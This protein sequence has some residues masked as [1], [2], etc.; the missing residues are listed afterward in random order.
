MLWYSIDFFN[1]TS[2]T[3]LILQ[4]EPFQ[5]VSW[6]VGTWGPPPKSIHKKLWFS[7]RQNFQVFLPPLY[8]DPPNKPW[9]IEP[10][11]SWPPQQTMTFWP[12][13]FHDLPNKPW[14]FD[15]T[16][17]WPTQQTI[18]NVWCHGL[19]GI[20]ETINPLKSLQFHPIFLKGCEK[21]KKS[22]RFRWG[23]KEYQQKWKNDIFAWRVPLEPAGNSD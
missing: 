19:M 11:K 8:H 15:P 22:F 5:K 4:W 10:T 1:V 13:L 3:N 17:S 23:G 2:F 9:H 7:S 21:K 18:T 20:Y 12:P 16:I 14:H 6:F